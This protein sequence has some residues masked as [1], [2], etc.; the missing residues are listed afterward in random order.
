[1][2]RLKQN[3]KPKTSKYQKKITKKIIS[4]AANEP[5]HPNDICFDKADLTKLQLYFL[6]KNIYK[7]H[8]TFDF[9]KTDRNF[10]FKSSHCF[11]ILLG[12]MGLIVFTVFYLVINPQVIRE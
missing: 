6:I 11:A 10:G 9:S 2:K 8:K 3:I 12:K 7:P 5:L 1:M 4:Y